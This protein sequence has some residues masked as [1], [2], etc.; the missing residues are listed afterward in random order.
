MTETTQEH[1]WV[2]KLE[3][4]V[5]RR[6]V[7]L[8]EKRDGCACLLE[9][10]PKEF[11]P[12]KFA[13]DENFEQAQRKWELC[14]LHYFNNRRYH[15]AL[16]VFGALYDNILSAQ[17][18]GEKWINKGTPLVWISDCYLH[19]RYPVLRK[20][21]LML[22]LCEDAISGH[23]HV[24][25][26][27]TG[28]YFRLVWG[29]G[30]SDL[31]LGQYAN[32]MYEL[33]KSNDQEARFPEWVL[34]ELG[35]QYWMTEFPSPEE[36]MVYSVSKPY[37]QHLLDNLPERTGKALER[38]AEYVLSC[39]PGCRTMRRME[40]P[41]TE[42][43]IVCSMEGVGLDF[44]SEFGRYFLCECKDW[45]EPA[46]FTAFAKF[47]RVLDSIKAR[48]GILFSA[49][50]ISSE[51]KTE[52]AEREQLKVFQDRGVV[53]VVVDRNDLQRVAEGA[54]F[55]NILRE[56]YDRVRLDLRPDKMEKG[57]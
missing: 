34:Q 12:D 11:P 40:T 17:S 38:L 49:K 5:P 35:D 21:Y 3:E 19:L 36:A 53:I 15:E 56:K 23:G 22:T 2:R 33:F 44:R 13:S 10:L 27:G 39:M 46:D 43:D 48:F 31:Q 16:S 18:Q 55:V 37:V 41:S 24:S 1:E 47:C 42:Y 28:T 26:E 29:H 7:E 20:R 9:E 51:G 52:D 54:N 50:G 4:N 30:L 6:L 8:L 57:S 45:K 14:G 25:P 32:K